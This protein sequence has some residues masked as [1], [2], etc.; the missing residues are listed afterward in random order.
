MEQTVA[1]KIFYLAAAGFTAGG[2]THSFLRG[3]KAFFFFLL[4][5]AGALL[6][7][8][9]LERTAGT[10]EA[11]TSGARGGGT[12]ALLVVFI[13]SAS[14]GLWRYSFS[15]KQGGLEQYARQDIVLRGII[16]D[17]P[18][19]RETNTRLILMARKERAEG[20][21]LLIAG[22]EPQFE[23]GD[24]VQVEGKLLRPQNFTDKET[25]REVDY[26]SHLDAR[27]IAYE[28]FRPKITLLERGKGNPEFCNCLPSKRHSRKI[29]GRCS[30][31]RTHRFLA[32]SLLAQNSRLERNFLMISAL[33][34]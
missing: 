23:Y 10:G 11:P 5:L 18:D 24:E 28:M 12:G 25:L 19:V 8:S 33:S 31:S 6:L 17:E 29:S 34:E 13:L 3:A 21:V 1:D 14:L 22:K 30:R 7:R 32:G 4:L 16:A 27:G 9:F 20:K 15:L 2:F 26:V